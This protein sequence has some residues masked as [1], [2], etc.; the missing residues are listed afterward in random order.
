MLTTRLWAAL[1]APGRENPIWQR[2][3]NQPASTFF[4]IRWLSKV[5][6]FTSPFVQL[7]VLIFSPLL[8]PFA[9]NLYGL[10]LAANVS[11]TIGREREQH[12]YDLLA[13]TPPGIARASWLICS[14]AV[15]RWQLV[16][17]V[18]T[19]RAFSVGVLVVSVLA[20]I[21][22]GLSGPIFSAVVILMLG[23]ECMQA[24][25]IG[26][27]SGI[28]AQ[29]LAPDVFSMRLWALGIF[30][31]EQILVGYIATLE[32]VHLL[33]HWFSIQEPV[34]LVV[35]Y[36]TLLFVIREGVIQLIWRALERK[37]T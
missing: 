16:A 20:T 34:I 13:L 1:G 8:L 24:V 7:V 31:A 14:A 19:L 11:D 27:L 23:T 25:I 21:S 35:L 37:L 4:L 12:T 3:Q 9:G 26:G 29:L 18:N 22:R 36:A 17:R 15:E 30:L 5:L 10:A 32:V 2:I 6:A 28:L 33:S